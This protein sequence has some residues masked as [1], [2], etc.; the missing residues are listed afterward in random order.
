[1]QFRKLGFALE[2]LKPEAL[3]EKEELED[4]EKDFDVVNKEG[5]ERGE[6]IQREEGVVMIDC[7][8]DYHN[9]VRGCECLIS[10]RL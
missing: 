7:S 9:I 4:Q 2:E 1:M 5:G 3:N 10:G 8:L 6:F